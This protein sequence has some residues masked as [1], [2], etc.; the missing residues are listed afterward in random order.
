MKRWLERCTAHAVL[1]IALQLAQVVIYSRYLDFYA[2]GLVFEL[3]EA[4]VSTRREAAVLKERKYEK[5]MLS[6]Q[7]ILFKL[8][9][10]K[11]EF[12]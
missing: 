4:A 8:C 7:S 2:Y 3:R 5:E 6:Y 9:S 11:V 1:V 10:E 12:C